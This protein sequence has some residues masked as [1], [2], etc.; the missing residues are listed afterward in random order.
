MPSPPHRLPASVLDDCQIKRSLVSDGCLLEQCVIRNSV[1][2]IRTRI[3]RDC[4][5]RDSIL[6]GADLFEFRA[7]RKANAAR[8]R[9]N[10]GIGAGSHIERA[11]V[12]KNA[13]IGA[14][15]R[16][17]NEAGVDT[18]DGESYVI[19]IDTVGAGVGETVLVKDEGT[20]A[21]QMLGTGPDGPVRSLIVGIVDQVNV[22]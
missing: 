1:L 12:D 10:V 16:L 18:A 13:R 22:E 11:I 19:A 8:G 7:D 9:P 3:A 2:G 20:S 6:M 15:V 17:I 4:I 21:R 5:I 14:N